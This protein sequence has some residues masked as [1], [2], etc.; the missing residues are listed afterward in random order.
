MRSRTASAARTTSC[1]KIEAAPALGL[2]SV[3]KMRNRVL[4]PLPLAPS[5][6]TVSPERTC[7]VTPRRIQREPNRRATPLASI[8]KSVVDSAIPGEK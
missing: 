5:R 6:P 8:A 7:N 1:P 2:S 4:L 3:P